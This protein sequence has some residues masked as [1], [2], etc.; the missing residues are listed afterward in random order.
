MI[1]SPRVHLAAGYCLLDR[2]GADDD[3][4][5][6]ITIVLI[7]VTTSCWT[8]SVTYSTAVFYRREAG[9]FI[10]DILVKARH[11][12]GQR[13]PPSL[14]APGHS[15]SASWAPLHITP[16]PVLVSGKD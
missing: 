16:L 2:L 10:S 9:V 3:D 15:E 11:L 13:S 7:I 12:R 6:I 4:D 5:D 14:A 1:P 8:E